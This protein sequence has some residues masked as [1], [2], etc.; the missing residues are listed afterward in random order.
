MTEREN[1]SQTL[2]LLVERLLF[3][4]AID[5]LNRCGISAGEVEKY[6]SA[7]ARG[8]LP[9]GF[10]SFRHFEIDILT[11]VK[12]GVASPAMKKSARVALKNLEKKGS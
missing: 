7:L 1:S 9:D 11:R 5:T 8:K 4:S 12:D 2:S 10:D 3:L 6:S